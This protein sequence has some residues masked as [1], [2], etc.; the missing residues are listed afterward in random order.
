MQQVT[1]DIV[2]IGRNEGELIDKAIHSSLMAAEEFAEL[3]YPK[4]KIVYMDGQSTDKSMEIA[5]G[6][7]ILCEVVQGKPNPA[8]GRHSGFKYC[9]SKYVFFLD[10]DM[11]IYPNWLPV[12]IKY[13]EEN[14]TT[15]AGVAGYCDWEVYQNGKMTK[16]PNHSGIQYHGQRVT[17]DVGGGFIYRADVLR[18]VGDFDPT[19]TRM[20]EFEMYLRI[21]AYG[22]D[23]VY[24]TI[25]MAIHRDLKD[26]MGKSFIRGSLLTRNVFIPGVIARK[27]PWDPKVLR[28]MVRRYWLFIWHSLSAGLLLI[29]LFMALRGITKS[30]GT[31]IMGLDFIQLFFAHWFYKNRIV[32]RAFVSL[33]TINIYIPAFIFGYLFSWPDVG[34]YYPQRRMGENES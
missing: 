22:Y 14:P 16:I 1:V 6:Y 4:P 31:L 2:I 27:A 15:I 7:G 13:L 12:A 3:G 17:T 26:G 21:V 29:F 11:E 34:G 20:G 8:L 18:E 28:L 32:K 19:M 30:T 24:L 5:R 9:T 25:P 23:L 10:G 33:I